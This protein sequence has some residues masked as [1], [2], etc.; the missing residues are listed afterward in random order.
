MV[1][2][3]DKIDPRPA[4]SRARLLEAATALLLKFLRTM[5]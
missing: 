2:I 3:T 4:R 5:P 1:Y